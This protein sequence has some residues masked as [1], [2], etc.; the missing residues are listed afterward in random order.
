M[1][2]ILV[3]DIRGSSGICLYVIRSYFNTLMK[4][5]PDRDKCM[6]CDRPA[7]WIRATQFAGDHPFC[8]EHAR[9]ESDFMV[10]DSY[11]FWYRIDDES[12]D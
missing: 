9:Q 4:K 7:V 8:E 5:M 12:E 6:M 1:Y 11:E 10:N 2:S 3:P